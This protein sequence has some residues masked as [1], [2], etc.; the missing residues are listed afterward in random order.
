[1]QERNKMKKILLTL[2][3]LTT[4]TSFSL[5]AHAAKHPWDSFDAYVPPAE[6][7]RVGQTWQEQQD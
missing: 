7:Q 1:M 4:L 2:G 6:Y 5:T 3:L